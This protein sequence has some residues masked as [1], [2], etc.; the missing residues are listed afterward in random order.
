MKQLLSFLMIIIISRPATAQNVGVGT[1]TPV[2][3]FSVVT[4]LEG[5][6]ITH[7][8]GSVQVGTYLTPANAQ[9]GTR[10]NHPLQ[11]FTNNGAAQ[12]TLMTNGNFGIGTQL[13]RFT[14]E[15]AGGIAA[16]G[17]GGG[18]ILEDR[19]NS[20]KHFQWYASNGN[21]FFYNQQTF[22]NN[23]A[24]V[25]NG[26]IGLNIDAPQA[27][28][29]INPAGAG[30]V[31]IGTNKN[32]GGYTNL[33]MG[34][35]AQSGGS[36]FIQCTRS[37][38]TS[39]GDLF[40]SPYGGYVGVGY[41]TNATL[42]APVD[43]NQSS[44]LR[45]LRLRNNLTLL[46]SNIWD[47]YVDNL[48]KFNSGGFLVATIG[49]DGSWNQVSDARL[50]TGIEKMDAVMD[51]VMALQPKKY[52][53][54]HNNPA[55]KISSGLLAQDLV[56]LFPEFVSDFKHPA[57]DTTDNTIYHAINYGG[58]SV[59][60]IKAIQEQ[61]TEIELLKEQNKMILEELNSLKAAVKN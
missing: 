24:I 10:S 41:A 1:L 15:V 31:L 17:N 37:S 32:A 50:K 9:F 42:F 28:L 57:G 34:I 36:S 59:I 26:S 7:S 44:S 25:N 33:E 30:S 6:G 27:R 47:I 55:Q 52:K 3:K 40:L 51:K 4:S 8:F 45:G 18:L 16:T 5:Y 13:P 20:G 48:L 12:V 39:Y 29:H 23:I 22:T 38:G 46:S 61:Q 53:Y 2:D 58:L 60:A 49:D 19:T 43:I 14:L 11:F 21:A 54:I 35:T 56:Q